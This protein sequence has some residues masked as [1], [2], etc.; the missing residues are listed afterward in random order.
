MEHTH[1]VAHSSPGRSG[2]E[3]EDDEEEG[4]L[5][6]QGWLEEPAGSSTAQAH[7]K[8]QEPAGSTAQPRILELGTAPRTAPQE[9]PPQEAPP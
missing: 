9:A 7:R 4:S 5:H 1:K 3:E 2:E 8:A 6:S